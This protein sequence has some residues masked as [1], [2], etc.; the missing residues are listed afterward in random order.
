MQISP[1][2]HA[3]KTSFSGKFKYTGELEQYI[4]TLNPVE[5]KLFKRN[6]ELMQQVNDGKVYTVKTAHK[7]EK[8][9]SRAFHVLYANG[10]KI[11]Q[12]S[13][14]LSDMKHMFNKI[15]DKYNPNRFTEESA[16][17]IK[18]FNLKKE[19]LSELKK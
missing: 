14:N 12:S 8:H 9:I 3:Q 4:H 5:F 13:G 19:F 6:T 10:R 18:L 16:E 17:Q 11:M 15:F 2:N 1:V 7:T